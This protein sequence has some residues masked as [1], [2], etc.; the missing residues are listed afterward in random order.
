MLCYK[1]RVSC[2]FYEILKRCRS[3][4]LYHY[5]KYLGNHNHFSKWESYTGVRASRRGWTPSPKQSL[6][7]K[8]R[9]F[10]GCCLLLWLVPY[11]CI[12]TDAPI[13]D[14]ASGRPMSVQW[15]N[16]T[17]TWLKFPL[18]AY[19]STWTGRVSMSAHSLRCSGLVAAARSVATLEDVPRAELGINMVGCT[20]RSARM[21][22]EALLHQVSGFSFQKQEDP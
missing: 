18:S 17:S 2:K 21:R 15:W 7:F 11:L 10:S 6:Y 3:E 4:R 12:S 20:K 16:P 8:A 14:Y 19:D 5:N 13:L 1:I 9:A 22:D